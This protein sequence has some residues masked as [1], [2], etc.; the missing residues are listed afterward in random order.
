M[1]AKM[2]SPKKPGSPANRPLP[3]SI[4]PTD[5]IIAAN[6]AKISDDKVVKREIVDKS[7][8]PPYPCMKG[9]RAV[10]P[11]YREAVADN[12]KA[13]KGVVSVPELIGNSN[14]S[15]VKPSTNKVN[16][17]KLAPPTIYPSMS[18]ADTTNDKQF[19]PEINLFSPPH[20]QNGESVGSLVDS[21]DL[22]GNPQPSVENFGGYN[23]ADFKDWESSEDDEADK[24]VSGKK[25][26]SRSSTKKKGPDPNGRRVGRK[27]VMWH[28]KYSCLDSIL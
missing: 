11:V 2:G 8:F 19:K 12:P 9:Y 27:L 21:L 22:H 4:A 24:A 15:P 6:S 18:T 25:A 20:I 7:T 26:R 13:F 5:T 16:E 1:K 28:R 14:T 10:W 17:P 3:S 23:K